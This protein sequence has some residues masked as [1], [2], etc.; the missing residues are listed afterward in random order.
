MLVQNYV[1]EGKKT[2]VK[3]INPKIKFKHTTQ[4]L[5]IGNPEKNDTPR[6]SQGTRD[7]T[8]IPDGAQVSTKNSWI[9]NSQFEFCS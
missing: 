4:H 3:K 6:L 2:E 9:S 8:T 7:F 1:S 5:Q